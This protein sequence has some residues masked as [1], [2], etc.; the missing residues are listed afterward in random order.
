MDYEWLLRAKK[1]NKKF[2]YINEIITNMSAGGHS[3]L[4]W[5][6]SIFE[7]AK[8]KRLYGLSLFKVYFDLGFM[9]LSG[10]L[11]RV[12]QKRGMERVDLFLKNRLSKVKRS[13]A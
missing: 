13:Y 4:N 11:S 2:H 5:H 8:I 12:L 9:F 7:M 1:S 6:R 10:T 3:D